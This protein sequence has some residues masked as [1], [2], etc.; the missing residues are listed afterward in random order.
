M[1]AFLRMVPTKLYR[2][3]SSGGCFVGVDLET[4]RLVEK[5][6]VLSQYKPSVLKHHPDT[7]VTFKDFGFLFS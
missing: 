3:V 6:F 7:G 5:G 2:Y 4:G 1:S